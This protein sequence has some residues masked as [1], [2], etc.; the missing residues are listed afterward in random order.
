MTQIQLDQ[1]LSKQC[2]KSFANYAYAQIK[3][4][5]GLKKKIVN[6]V[7]EERKSVL[8]FCFVYNDG[9]SLPL[10]RFLTLKEIDQKDCG[11]ANINHLKDCHNLYHNT[12][13]PYKG[14]IKSKKSQ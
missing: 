13:I 4:A 9:K 1:F 10:K 11:I 8:D 2:E 14:I 6:P 12:D 7:E 3:K 5:R